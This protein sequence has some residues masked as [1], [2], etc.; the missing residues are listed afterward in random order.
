MYTH[1]KSITLLDEPAPAFILPWPD[2]GSRR[3]PRA[4]AG[5]RRTGRS[6][7]HDARGQLGEV[8]DSRRAAGPPRDVLAVSG[9][10][11]AVWRPL[12]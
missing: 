4:G 3:P 9:G 1:A 5:D 10:G 6:G 11:N 2:Q 8:R 12:P 7:A